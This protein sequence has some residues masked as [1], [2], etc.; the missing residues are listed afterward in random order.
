[1]NETEESKPYTFEM[2]SSTLSAG[3]IVTVGMELARLHFS[4]YFVRSLL[5][6]LWIALAVVVGVLLLG[7]GSGLGFVVGSLAQFPSLWVGLGIGVGILVAIAGLAYASARFTATGGVMARMGINTLRRWYEPGE[8]YK[9]TIFRQIWRYL[10]ASTV[11]GIAISIVYLLFL[12]LGAGLVVLAQSLWQNWQAQ[13]DPRS[14]SFMILG[15]VLLGLLY[16][17]GIGLVAYYLTARFWLFDA[18]LAMEPQRSSLESLRRSWELTRDRGWNITTVMFVTTLITFPLSGIA[19][20]IGTVVPF[21][22]SF[23]GILFFPLW[24]AV[25]AAAYY[26]LAATRTGLRFDLQTSSFDPSHFLRRVAIQTP[27][28]LALDFALGGLGSRALAWIVDQIILYL[29]LTAL[30]LVGAIAYGYVVVPVVLDR[31]EVSIDQLNLWAAAIASIVGFFISNGYFIYCETFRRGQTP[32]K[33]L[34]RIRVVRDNSQPIGIREAALRSFIG[35][36]DL[37]F[38]AIGLL[39]IVLNRSEK[40]LGDL[41]A[42]T[43]VI[44]D[45]KALQQVLTI[46]NRFSTLTE[47]TV[48][49]LVAQTDPAVLSVGQYLILRSFLGYRDWLSPGDRAQVTQKL[50]A[51]LRLLLMPTSPEVL[52]TIP[53]ESLIEA[54]YL[55]NRP[56]Y[57]AL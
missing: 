28:G 9:Q 54:V 25:K 57:Q 45:E 30:L 52:G 29:L 27:E 19:A 16:L 17:A 4:D 26:D 32:G 33:Q 46:P 37:G 48:A 35:W 11:F 6:H 49:V 44:Q 13:V 22:S 40:R 39:L 56:A 38:F 18:V 50:A 43:I 10:I 31:F 7:L 21:A 8:L 5:A 2:N 36:I 47:D 23:A 55:E 24:Q 42:G 3:N 14:Q 15:A 53:D 20:V 34:A 12:G 1:V 51:Q 41:A